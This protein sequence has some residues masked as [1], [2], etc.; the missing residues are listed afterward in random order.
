MQ[1]LIDWRRDEIGKN[2]LIRR[3]LRRHHRQKD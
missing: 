2:M 3:I 1:A